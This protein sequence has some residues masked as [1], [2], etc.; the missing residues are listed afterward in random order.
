[1][2]GILRYHVRATGALGA[3]SGTCVLLIFVCATEPLAGSGALR[4]RTT[5]TQLR[6]NKR[7]YWMGCLNESICL[8]CICLCLGSNLAL[9]TTVPL[10]FDLYNLQDEMYVK[11]MSYHL[12]LRRFST[13]HLVRITLDRPPL[14]KYYRVI[15]IYL[16]LYFVPPCIR[17]S[18]VA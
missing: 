1:M 3:S 8:W 12:V 2:E 10:A 7:A 9:P 15:Y 11:L 4:I 5:L 17:P 16:P 6:T 13:N 18:D 14:V